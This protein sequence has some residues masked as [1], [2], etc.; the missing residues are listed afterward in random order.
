MYVV[1][2]FNQTC[3]LIF[4]IQLIIF[5]KRGY[6]PLPPLAEKFRYFRQDGFVDD[7]LEVTVSFGLFGS[8]WWTG[9]GE[10]VAVG[11]GTLS[12]CSNVWWHLLQLATLYLCFDWQ[13]FYVMTFSLTV[14]TKFFCFKKFVFDIYWTTYE[15][16][17]SCYYMFFGTVPTF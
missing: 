12:L 4:L 7:P 5:N 8:P 10:T 3:I 14:P 6:K 15:V 2:Q 11:G 16:F 13:F 9:D 17:T 1:V